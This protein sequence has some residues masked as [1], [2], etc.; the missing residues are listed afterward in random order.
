MT[1]G[2]VEFR[3]DA[4][5]RD[6]KKERLRLKRVMVRRF[7]RSAV[8]RLSRNSRVMSRSMETRSR[9]FYRWRFVHNRGCAFC[10]GIGIEHLISLKGTGF[11]TSV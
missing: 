7:R 5:S 11:W 6:R 4:G 8:S 3:W 9:R 10:K 2:D 1:E